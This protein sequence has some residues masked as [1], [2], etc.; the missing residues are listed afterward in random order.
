M[1]EGYIKKK[2]ISN[3]RAWQGCNQ[4]P[5]KTTCTD[6]PSKLRVRDPFQRT[7]PDMDQRCGALLCEILR[8]RC[9]S[10]RMTVSP[11]VKRR[12]RPRRGFGKC[13][14]HPER[15]R[16]AAKAESKDLV[17]RFRVMHKLEK[18]RRAICPGSYSA[19]GDP[20]HAALIGFELELIFLTSICSCQ[21]ISVRDDPA[22]V[23]VRMISV[24]GISFPG[25]LKVV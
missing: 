16:S 20:S 3:S 19:D 24:A 4:S 10:L 25:H 22:G 11:R 1:T 7:C 21:M 18:I 14:C 23:W 6:S 2:V 5:G 13:P 17:I 9:A 8:L 15:S 12:G